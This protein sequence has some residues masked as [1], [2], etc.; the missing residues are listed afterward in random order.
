MKLH[1]SL[2]REELGEITKFESKWACIA[3][4]PRVKRDSDWYFDDCFS[5]SLQSDMVIPV[6]HWPAVA[7]VSGFQ[8]PQ[9]I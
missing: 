1:H 3:P 8:R 4:P 7:T 9:L 6:V 2:T 5:L